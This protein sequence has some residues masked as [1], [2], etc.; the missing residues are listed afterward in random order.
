[1]VTV[2]PVNNT[3]MVTVTPVV[4]AKTGEN[5]QSNQQLKLPGGATLVAVTDRN[6][7]TILKPKLLEKPHVTITIGDKQIQQPV[8]LLTNTVNFI[9]SNF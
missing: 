9:S 5:S 6:A 3:D 1:M 7:D 4:I 8:C 2:T